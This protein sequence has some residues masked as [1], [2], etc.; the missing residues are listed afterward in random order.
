[1][2]A[3]CWTGR[4]SVTVENVP[5]PKIMNADDAIVRHG[6]S[7]AEVAFLQKPFTPKSMAKKVREVLDQK[8]PG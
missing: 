3:N 8:A 6:I 1:M 5:E 4:N 2:K 7:Q